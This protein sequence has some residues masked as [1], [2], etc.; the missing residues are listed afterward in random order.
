MAVPLLRGDTNPYLVPC[1][2]VTMSALPVRARSTGLVPWMQTAASV[3]AALKIV[4]LQLRCLV[5]ARLPKWACPSST[6][7]GRLL[8]AEG[9]RGD[10]CVT[11]EQQSPCAWFWA[12]M[13]GQPRG[14]RG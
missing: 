12:A 14:Q 9:F 7:G 6:S 13:A 11:M 8:R 3:T 1:P 10:I 2:V 5:S 4:V